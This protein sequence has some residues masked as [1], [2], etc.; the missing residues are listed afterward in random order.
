MIIS[1]FIHVATNGFI[2]FFLWL[3]NIPLCIC[4]TSSLS[5]SLSMDIWVASMFWLLQTVLQWTLGCL[6]LL[7]L[8]FSL[9]TCPEVGLLDHMVV[10]YLV[11]KGTSILFSIMLV[12]IYIATNNV[13]GFLFYIPSP[14]FVICRLWMSILTSEMVPYYNFDLHFSNN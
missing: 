8:W 10:L 1:R 12:Q 9:S 11:F 6:Y 2:S 4:S 3:S 14:A 7:E 13:G 5:P